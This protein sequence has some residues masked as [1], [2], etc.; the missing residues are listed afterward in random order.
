MIFKTKYNHFKYSV[1]LF[2]LFNTRARFQNYINKIL[3]R[4][5]DIVVIFDLCHILI[6]MNEVDYNNSV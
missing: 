5:L 6:Y 4:E 2:G 3:A 1:I